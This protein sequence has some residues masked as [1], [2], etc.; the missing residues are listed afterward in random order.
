MDRGVVFLLVA[1]NVLVTLAGDYFIKLAS[2]PQRGPLSL[3]FVA[4]AA[5]YALTALGWLYVMRGA[6]LTEVAV[7]YSA[8][9]LVLLSGLGVV[10]FDEPFGGREAL[11][12]ALALAS[13]LVMQRG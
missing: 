13:V 7:Y 11:G 6:S 2:A 12:V 4:G 8:A 3:A 9:T 1:V 5:A 10:A